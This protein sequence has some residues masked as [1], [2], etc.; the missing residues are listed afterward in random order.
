MFLN[1]LLSKSQEK[2]NSS[3][4]MVLSP[5]LLRKH[6]FYQ[7][8]QHKAIEQL[9]II[10]PSVLDYLTTG[11]T[12]SLT[13]KGFGPFK[14]TFTQRHWVPAAGAHVHLL[15]LPFVPPGGA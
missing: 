8:Q 4:K 13:G 12:G 11:L 3:S 7:E 15:G 1:H 9:F 6:N 10:F 14:C 5:L 2:T